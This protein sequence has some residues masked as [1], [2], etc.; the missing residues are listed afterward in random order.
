MSSVG[1]SALL[2]SSGPNSG[3]REGLW[4][5][6]E[7]SRLSGL[8]A[9]GSALPCARQVA[10]Q[11]IVIFREVHCTSRTP[12]PAPGWLHGSPP[13][14]ALLLRGVPREPKAAPHTTQ[15]CGKSNGRWQT[16]WRP[17][18]G[19]CSLAAAAAL[20]FSTLVTAC[21]G[22]PVTPQGPT[23]RAVAHTVVSGAC[24]Q[25]P[26]AVRTG[27]TMQTGTVP[28]LHFGAS[29]GEAA[30]MPTSGNAELWN[31]L[32]QQQHAESSSA[33]HMVPQL[34][35][36]ALPPGALQ[37]QHA[38]QPVLASKPLE[39]AGQPGQMGAGAGSGIT[40][41]PSSLTSLPGIGYGSAPQLPPGSMPQHP[42]PQLY[43]APPPMP[44]PASCAAGSFPQLSGL[45]SQLSSGMVLT[46]GGAG[47]QQLVPSSHAMQLSGEL[48]CRLVSRVCLCLG[49]S[50][51]P[52]S[53]AVATCCWARVIINQSASRLPC[54]ICCW[55][56]ELCDLCQRSRPVATYGTCMLYIAAACT[57]LPP[58]LS[59]VA[60]FLLQALAWPRRRTCQRHL[61]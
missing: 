8:P 50:A 24:C 32:Q 31:A 55:H 29:G 51:Q 41:L 34:Q 26:A 59:T 1:F 2:R 54:L 57:S 6:L 16:H 49:C 9:R 22:I 13:F 14:A 11:D 37:P 61:S 20:T 10:A 58:L 46:G 27:L 43:G 44:A 19:I 40:G 28:Q 18:Q 52:F 5:R 12:C 56:G 42:L 4:A 53:V 17:A 36:Y 35:G 38:Q 30:T 25:A 39:F 21:T 47:T 23:P 60:F 7:V 33:P 48:V 45:S 3:A 15:Q